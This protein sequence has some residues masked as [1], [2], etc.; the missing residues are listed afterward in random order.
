MKKII[1]F[2]PDDLIKN[3]RIFYEYINDLGMDNGWDDGNQR[4]NFE[5]LS[6]IESLAGRS[7]NKAAI[8]DVGCGTG[9]L[10]SFLRKKGISD[11]VGIDIY[12]PSLERAR[13][14]YPQETF[15]NGDLLQLDLKKLFDY[16]FCSGGLTLR[17]TIDNYDFLYSMINRMWEV[18]TAGVAF[19]F[20]SDDDPDPDSDLFFYNP[21]KVIALCQEIAPD[22]VI[23]A[24]TS[25]NEYQVTVYM[26]RENLDLSI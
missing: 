15:I 5:Y 13:E 9:D 24:V 10:S 21:E 4:E 2:P 3:T 12:E 18:S 22:A 7:F 17:L 20:L 1:E 16:V 8:L 11:Y 26:Y 23:S 14:R 6:R 19:N 25:P